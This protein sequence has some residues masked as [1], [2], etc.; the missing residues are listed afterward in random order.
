M[1]MARYESCDVREFGSHR[2]HRVREVIATSARLQS[3]VTCEDNRVRAFAFR[4]RYCAAHRLHRVLKIH[5]NRKLPWKPERHARRC[6][7]DKCYF[8]ALNFFNDEWLNLCERMLRIARGS[9]RFS[10]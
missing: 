10:A 3:H 1:S 6:D 8:D 5:S 2:H 9:G 7:S 4:F